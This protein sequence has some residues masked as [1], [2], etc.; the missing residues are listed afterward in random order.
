LDP[1]SS[2]WLTLAAASQLLGVHPMTLRGWVDA[3][4]VSAYRTPG[5]HRRFRRSEL[6]SF[7]EQQ[8]NAYARRTQSVPQ[9]QT[10]ALIRQDLS[11]QALHRA[12][13]Y[14]SMTEAQRTHQRELGQR[15]LGLLIQYVSRRENAEQFLG[16]AQELAQTYGREIAQTPMSAADL[17][18]AFLFFRRSV[19]NATYHAGGAHTQGD[20][21]GLRL[22]E[23]I[24]TFMDELLIVTLDAYERT[25]A[26]LVLR[27]KRRIPARAK[28]SRVRRKT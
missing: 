4:M 23:R 2:D 13:W 1:I 24:N 26:H 16:Q 6:Q 14:S 9:E 21:E 11:R 25:R 19:L 7:L 18:R 3:G 22:L 28:K 20:A 8:R 15:L 10:L 5:G 17:A 27:R 12:N